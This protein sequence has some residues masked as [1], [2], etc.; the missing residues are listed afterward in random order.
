MPRVERQQSGWYQTD[1]EVFVPMLQDLYHAGGF[2]D[3]YRRILKR[4][5]DL[6]RRGA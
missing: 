6:E 1:R 3:V 2:V 4:L 5:E